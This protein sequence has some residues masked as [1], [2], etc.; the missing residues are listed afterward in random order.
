MVEEFHHTGELDW[1]HGAHRGEAA[2]AEN[3]L[4]LS[5]FGSYLEVVSDME[6]GRN[7]RNGIVPCSTYWFVHGSRLLGTASF[8]EIGAEV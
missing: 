7:F 2:L 8:G 6:S 4:A 1:P 5:D 3:D